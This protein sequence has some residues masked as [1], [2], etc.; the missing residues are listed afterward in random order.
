MPG[1]Q[2]NAITIVLPMYHPKGEWPKQFIENV[3]DLNASL[4]PALQ[5]EYIVVHDGTPD[6]SAIDSFKDI[7]QHHKEIKFTWYKKNQGKGYALRYGVALS[8]F[9][10]VLTMDFDFPYCK[11]SIIE[12]IGLLHQGHDVIVGK[13]SSDYFQQIPTKR[14]I[15]SKTCS[16]L[17]SSFLGLP[18][19]DT[20]SGIKGFNEKGRAV[21]LQTTIKRFL[22]DTEFILRAS[23]KN[24]NMKTIQIQPKPDL[25]FS[26]FGF[27]VIKTETGNFLKLLYLNQSLAKTVNHSL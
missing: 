14:K 16:W 4:S 23:K 7:C 21:F 12:M 10:N 26:N 19:K 2:R 18:L 3:R 5:L 13:R 22:V 1:Q 6:Q 15:I 24:L 17:A 27:R 11:E 25:S 9:P 8:S 20:Q